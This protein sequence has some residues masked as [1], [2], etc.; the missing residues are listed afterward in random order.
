MTSFR[1]QNMTTNNV[2]DVSRIENI[3]SE[4]KYSVDSGVSDTIN[5]IKSR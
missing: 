4:M 2:V 1:L 3:A 5:W